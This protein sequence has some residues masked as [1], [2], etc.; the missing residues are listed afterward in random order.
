M[1]RIQGT[2]ALA[3]GIAQ[4]MGDGVIVLCQKDTERGPQS[5]VVTEADLR[6]L[7]AASG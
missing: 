5:V 4:H 7:L 1:S 6:R 3:D 2:T